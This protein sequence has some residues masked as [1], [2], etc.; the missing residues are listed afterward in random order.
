MTRPYVVTTRSLAAETA[1]ADS[2]V[3]VV[4][5][6]GV[7]L[8]AV[9]DRDRHRRR[10]AAGL[11]LP[12]VH[13]RQRADD[14]VRSGP[15]DEVGERRRRL[16]E[17]HVVGEASAEAEAVEEPQPAEAAPLVRAQLAGERRRLDLLAAAWCRAVRRAAVPTTPP[18][19][20]V[21]STVSTSASVVEAQ[22]VAAGGGLGGEVE[23]GE[24][25]HLA[26]RTIAVE[27]SSWRR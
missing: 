22:L 14:E 10:E 19:R 12:V 2:A 24:R 8:G 11:G 1:L 26:A 13:H 23:E 18:R 25:A 21:P 4:V 27:A 9:V 16:A 17:T 20:S 5:V 6:G 7:A 15:V 3:A